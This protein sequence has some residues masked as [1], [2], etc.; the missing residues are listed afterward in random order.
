LEISSNPP[1]KLND[2]EEQSIRREAAVPR[3]IHFEIPADDPERAV[4]FYQKVFGWEI[5]KWGPA[6]YWLAKTGTEGE[7]GINGAIMTRETQKTT[8]NTISVSSVDEFAQKIV[9]GGGKVVAPKMAIPGVG[10]FAYC[11]D[12]EGNVF[13]VMQ[14]DPKAH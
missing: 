8:V 12:T 9:E 10:Y 11:V 2:R 6:D 7:P 1:S 5:N 13:G 4:K 3:V 14:E